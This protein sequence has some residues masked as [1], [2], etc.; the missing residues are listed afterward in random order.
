MSA[1]TAY[2]LAALLVLAAAAVRRRRG[3]GT[4]QPGSP[5]RRARGKDPARLEA[6]LDRQV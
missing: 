3:T 6:L 5:T 1:A 2:G 4:S